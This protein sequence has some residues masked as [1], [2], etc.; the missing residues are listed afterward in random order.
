MG[1]E[2]QCSPAIVIDIELSNGCC[3][4][5]IHY[6]NIT[7]YVMIRALEQNITCRFY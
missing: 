3:V 1:D 7:S 2:W 6:C 5:F 4:F